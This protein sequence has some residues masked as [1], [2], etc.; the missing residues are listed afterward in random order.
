M[1]TV[2]KVF[3]VLNLILA[4]L[5]GFVVPV[6][7][8]YQENYKRRWAKDTAAM[9]QDV[10][11]A[12]FASL[13]QSFKAKQFEV[14]LQS[15]NSDRELL[16]TQV[17]AQ[18]SQI[19]QLAAEKAQLNTT[20]SDL[21]TSL[22]AQRELLISR[23]ASLELERKRRSELNKIAQVARAVA[24]QLNVKLAEVEDDL[25]NAQAELTRRERTIFDME[26]DLK[27]KNAYLA[28]VRENHPQVYREI[29]SDVPPSDKVIRAVVAAVRINP[30]GKQDLVMLTV[31]SD[32]GIREGMEFIIYRANEYI[33]KVRAERVMGDMVAGRVI[34]DTWNARGDEIKQGDL[35]QNRLF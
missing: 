14:L 4:A 22:N 34:A 17:T 3:I 29:T 24:F 12:N 2:T 6:T 25:N 13:D 8:A 18:L 33:V 27:R 26:E 5:V 35:A 28:L 16:A 1:N 7:Y 21:N 31:G 11:D 10:K 19:E 20:V 15:A 30:Q 32:E 9:A 23:E